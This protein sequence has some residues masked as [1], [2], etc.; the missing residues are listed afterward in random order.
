MYLYRAGLEEHDCFLT[1]AAEGPPPT[2]RGGSSGDHM[3]LTPR[4][5]GGGMGGGGDA[6]AEAEHGS[7]LAAHF[8]RR[9]SLGGGSGRL[10][11]AP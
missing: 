1:A 9:A 6:G 5:G 8:A 2:P 11:I 3:L 10:S 7:G 4:A